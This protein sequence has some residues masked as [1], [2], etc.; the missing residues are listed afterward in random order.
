V[1]SVFFGGVHDFASIIASVRHGGK[2]VGE[3]IEEH[4]GRSGQRLFLVFAW[5]ALILVVAVFCR[6]IASTF[7]NAPES[8]TS[9]MLFIILAVL[10]GLGIYRLRVHLGIATVVGV[11]LLFLCVWAGLQ[12]P[13]HLTYNQWMGILFIY[14]FIAAVTPVWI[15]LQPRDFLNSFLLYFLL[16]GGIVGIFVANPT[17]AFPA[18]TGFQTNLG[19]LFPILFVTVAC[20]AIS[21]FHSMVSS[22]TTSK[23]LNKETDAKLVGYGSMLVEGLLAVVALITAV[24]VLRGR[25]DQ[26][27]SVEGG[28]PI[29]IFSAGLGGFISSLGIPVEVG[30]T[31]AALAI[32]AFALTSL[33]TAT[34]LARFVFQEFFESQGRLAGLGRNRY[35][36]TLI[37][38]VCAAALAM[39]G[40]SNSIWPLFGSANQ[41]IA[42][43]ALLAVTVWLAKMKKKN[44]FVKIPMIFMFAVT[45]TALGILIVQNIVTLNITQLVIS[46]LLFVVAVSLVFQAWRSL[47][48]IR[49]KM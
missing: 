32:S 12:T 29:G 41:L 25:Y 37:T 14:I 45:V 4:I 42:A 5:L 26:M 8:A 27:I 9:S 11:A 13:I 35:L 20:G 23:Q 7:V 30:V 40:K 16:L 33:D 31:F 19:T 24:T 44:G 22:G 6:A 18:L 43:I 39:S 46:I 21:G 1:G 15:L 38:V 49:A 17:I 47:K 48:A 34:R 36:G 28:G 2:T 10:F 3:V